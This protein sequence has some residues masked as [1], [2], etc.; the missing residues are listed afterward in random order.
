M[1]F[2]HNLGLM[3]RVLGSAALGLFSVSTLSPAGSK[4]RLMSRIIIFTAWLQ[5]NVAAGSSVLRKAE[6]LPHL[7]SRG[8]QLAVSEPNVRRRCAPINR[9]PCWGR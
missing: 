9:D 4:V 3:E 2:I 1:N 6:P 7:S 8:Q 5:E